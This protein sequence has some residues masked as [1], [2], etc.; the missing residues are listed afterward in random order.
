[1][2]RRL[3]VGRADGARPTGH[4][5]APDLWIETLPDDL[6]QLA[7]YWRARQP[8]PQECEH[9]LWQRLRIEWSYSSNHIEG[10]TLT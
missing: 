3:R 6:R 5:G 4:M 1:M 8:L 7:R 10:N 9:R 2:P